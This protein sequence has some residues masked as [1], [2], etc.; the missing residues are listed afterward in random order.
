MA[1]PSLI[2]FVRENNVMIAEY[3]TDGEKLCQFIETHL[4]SNAKWSVLETGL[5]YT[6]RKAELI[7]FFH[8]LTTVNLAGRLVIG[9]TSILEQFNIDNPQFECKLRIFLRKNLE[10]PHHLIDETYRFVHRSVQAS[11]ENISDTSRRKFKK[12]AKTK[13]ARCYLC[14]VG[15][16]FDNA[17]S[18]ISFTCDHIWPRS[19]GGNS[20]EDNL[21]PACE[22]CNSKKKGNFATW[23]MPA[24]QSLIMGFKPTSQR[25]KEIEGCYKFALH[26]KIAQQLAAQ[27]HLSLKRA[28]LKTGTWTDIRVSNPDDVADFFNLENYE[29]RPYLHL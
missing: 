19:Y 29:S 27:E 23:V 25:L 17:N 2:V 15:L 24:I 4:I 9:G 20:I 28:F 26:Y 7:D 5:E 22:S 21:L 1:K 8:Q 12:W 11:Q 3:V 13:H 14:G 18:P 16:D 10:I 6:G